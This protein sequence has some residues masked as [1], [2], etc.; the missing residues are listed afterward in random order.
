MNTIFQAKVI[1]KRGLTYTL[2]E[3]SWVFQC[4]HCEYVMIALIEESIHTIER[5]HYVSAHPKELAAKRWSE[6]PLSSL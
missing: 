1:R 5:T 2:D 6:S 3:L 4:Q